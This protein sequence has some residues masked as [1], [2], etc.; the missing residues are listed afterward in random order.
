[1]VGG[2]RNELGRTLLTFIL[3]PLETNTKFLCGFGCTLLNP[4]QIVLSQF[5]AD[6]S[7]LKVRSQ[8]SNL[9]L[10]LGV[11]FGCMENHTLERATR[12]A[13]RG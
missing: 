12:I 4:T 2:A 5:L 9:L 8:I 7:T 6:H 13:Q 10:W 1:V 3:T 11:P